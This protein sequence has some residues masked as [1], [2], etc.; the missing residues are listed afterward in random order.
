MKLAIAN[1][2][3]RKHWPLWTLAAVALFFVLFLTVT[4]ARIV[5]DARKQEL[6]PADAIVVLVRLSTM[7]GHPRSCGRAS[8]MPT[9]S[10]QSIWHR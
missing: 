5:S 1:R 3:P 2:F 8:T 7:A 4:C 10:T 6:H 9:I